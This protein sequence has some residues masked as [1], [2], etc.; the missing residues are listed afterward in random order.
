MRL[1]RQRSA[2]SQT[3]AGRFDNF[4]KTKQLVFCTPNVQVATHARHVAS[5]K[6]FYPLEMMIRLFL[7][8]QHERRFE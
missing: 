1:G 2:S 5:L 3:H 7:F 4:F 8:E 6:N